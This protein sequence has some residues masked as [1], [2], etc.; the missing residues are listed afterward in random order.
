VFGAVEVFLRLV[1]GPPP[2]PVRVYTMLGQVE[3][4]LVERDGHVSTTYQHHEPTPPFPAHAPGPRVAFLGGS[5]VHAGSATPDGAPVQEFPAVVEHLTGIPCLNLGAPGADS[6]DLVAILDELLAWPV[7]ACVIYTGHC[8][9]GNAY[10]LRR[11]AGLGGRVTTRLL[12][13]LG[14]SQLFAQLHRLLRPV[15]DEAAP[16]MSPK[17]RQAAWV[18]PDEVALLQTA[19]EQNLRY[20]VRRCRRAGVQPVLVAPASNLHGRPVCAAPDREPDSMQ[21]WSEG[22][23]LLES[24]PAAGAALLREARDHDPCPVRATSA[25]V[26]VV[27]QLAADEVVPLVDAE[28]DLPRSGPG[29]VPARHLFVDDVHLSAEGH[30]ELAALIAPAIEDL[31]D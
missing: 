4:Y 27:R 16:L 2:P 22:L 11:Y 28:R 30:R 20:L 10:F 31:L 5:S 14:R 3:S 9:V 15:H 21:L 13:L 19:F 24:D 29:G 7:T 8:D 12:P 18:P 1:L 6:H 17:A 26:D 23:A 25:L